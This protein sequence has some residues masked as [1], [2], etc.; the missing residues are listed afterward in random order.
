MDMGM[1]PAHHVVWLQGRGYETIAS[2]GVTVCFSV[3]AA[4]EYYCMMVETAKNKKFVFFFCFPAESGMHNV[5]L[6]PS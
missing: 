4:T 2:R 6:L 5:L 3:V 1:R